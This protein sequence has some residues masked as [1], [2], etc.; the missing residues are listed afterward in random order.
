LDQI[1]ELTL[2]VR[3]QAESIN[4]VHKNELAE[5]IIDGQ[6]AILPD[7]IVNRKADK[8]LSNSHF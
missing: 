4:A 7:R 5:T 1:Q 6:Q 3:I 8:K 2:I